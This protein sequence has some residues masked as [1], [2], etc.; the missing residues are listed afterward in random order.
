[1]KEIRT[2]GKGRGFIKDN[3]LDLKITVETLL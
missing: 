3:E 1:M 2:T